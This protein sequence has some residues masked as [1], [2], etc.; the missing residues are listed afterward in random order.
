MCV[1]DDAVYEKL[2][3]L[4]LH[5]IDK[6]A[7]SRYTGS[8]RHWDMQL[9][10]WK[11][12]ISDIQSALLVGQL[13]KIEQFLEKREALAAFYKN[14][15]DA[16]GVPYMKGADG[17]KSAR[18]LFVAQVENR[19]DVLAKMQEN[20]IGVAV[21]YRPIHLNSYYREAFGF[22]G[23]EFPVA[24]RIGERC[25]SLPLYPLLSMDEAGRVVDALARAIK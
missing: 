4:R 25:I 3:K 9:L 14:A 16:L 21:N 5:G 20:G 8:Y 12:N 15:L 10:G 1:N 23:G 22:A 7:A 6:D 18:H 13:A 17:A 11:Y 2:A 24:E 19:D